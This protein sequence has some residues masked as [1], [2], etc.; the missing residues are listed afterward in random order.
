MEQVVRDFNINIEDVGDASKNSQATASTSL[1][2]SL[3]A[4]YVKKSSSPSSLDDE[5]NR[6]PTVNCTDETIMQFWKT[7]EREFPK[8][9]KIA[10]VLLGI[11]M[12][13]AKSESAFSTAGCLIRKDRAS[14]TPYRIE[15]TLFIHDNYDI[16]NM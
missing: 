7:N 12:T 1:V 3:L 5:L 2:S 6:F 9:A 16:L 13:S 8:L 11:P 14:L 10:K 4:K 15:R